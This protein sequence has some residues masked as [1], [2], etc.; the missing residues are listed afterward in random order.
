MLD[1]IAIIDIETTGLNPTTDEVI[2]I[3]CVLF[4]L[5]HKTVLQQLSTLVPV[6]FDVNPV[7]HL[8]GI[9]AG[10]ANSMYYLQHVFPV[11][12]AIK[13]LVKNS[14]AVVAHNASFDRS[15]IGPYLHEVDRPKVSWIDSR[16]I[17]WPRANRQGC[18][19]VELAL[20]YGIPVWSNHRALTD[21]QLLA[22]IIQREP[23]AARLLARELEPKVWVT[24]RSTPADKAGHAVARAAGFRW[25]DKACPVDKVW[26]RQM[27]ADDVEGLP[28]EAVV[29]A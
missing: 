25:N 14:D 9:S 28:F 21:C 19:L 2:E 11:E 7:E 3:G 26:S 13:E 1:L 22:H 27:H 20:A 5:S 23:D 10:A 17:T 29:V 4:S 12:S 18:N 8:N 16:A 15:F 24:W 6:S